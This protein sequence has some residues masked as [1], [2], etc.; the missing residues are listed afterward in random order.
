MRTAAC[1][2][3]AIFAGACGSTPAE[4]RRIGPPPIDVPDGGPVPPDGGSEPCDGGYCSPGEP[5]GGG[6]SEN[7]DPWK[8]LVIVDSSVVLDGRASSANNGPWSFRQLM[9]RFGSPDLVESWLRTYRQTSL[10]GFSLDDRVDVEELIASW[11]RRDGSLD[12]AEAPFRLLA[13]VNRLDLASGE[14]GEARVIYGL[15][16]PASGVPRKMTVA[17]EYKLPALGSANDRTEW[18]RRWHALGKIPFGETYNAAL[19][20]LTDVFAHGGS[21]SQL[22]ANEQQFGNFWQLREWRFEGGTLRLVPTPQT[23]DQSLNGSARLAQFILDNADALRAGTAAVPTDLLGG[24]SPE[25]GAWVFKGEARIDEPL[26]HAFARQTCNGCHAQ[27]TNSVQGFFHVSPFK[28]LA[29]NGQDRVSDFLKED[30][31]GR[32]VSRLRELLR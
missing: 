20:R 26:R 25:I 24:V 10:N 18:A 16:D 21:L 27:E 23:P 6:I 13:I 1:A 30:D 8:E 2:V 7:V 5:D 9:E 4:V 15:Y 17:F 22:R 19:Q 12:L 11:P 28:P 14:N 3:L 32:R 29:G 31:M